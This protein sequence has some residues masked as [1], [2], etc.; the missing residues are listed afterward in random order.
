MMAEDMAR[1]IYSRYKDDYTLTQ[2][3]FNYL[4]EGRARMG[5]K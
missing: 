3:V 1:D 4:H 2:G 5:Y